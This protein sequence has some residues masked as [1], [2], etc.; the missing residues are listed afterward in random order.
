MIYES[1]KQDYKTR[2]CKTRTSTQK[3]IIEN[4][5]DAYFFVFYGGNK[6]EKG[7]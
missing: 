3:V 1:L 5:S 7:S 6:K 2:L 4:Q